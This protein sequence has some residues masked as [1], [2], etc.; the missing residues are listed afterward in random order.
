MR[1]LVATDG[2]RYSEA[3]IDSAINLSWPDDVEFKVLTVADPYVYRTFPPPLIIPN[4]SVEELC[5]H[6]SEVVSAAA[7]KLRRCFPKA[8]VSSLVVSGDARHQIVGVA[9]EWKAD[10]VFMGAHGK[11][12]LERLLPGSVSEAVARRCPSSVYVARVPH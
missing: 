2:S 5:D 1:I 8:V 7:R 4:S 3:A 9:R 12:C 6:A 11:S 10:C